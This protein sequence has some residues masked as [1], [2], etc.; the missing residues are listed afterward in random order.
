[1][2]KKKERSTD[3]TAMASKK[4]LDA[5]HAAMVRHDIAPK[6]AIIMFG[7]FARSIVD[8]EVD[9][10]ANKDQFTMMVLQAFTDGLGVKGGFVEMQGELAEQ[11]K[12]QFD[13]QNS[14]TP[15]Q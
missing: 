14:D 6:L 15:L 2:T 5:V 13:Q 3:D 4:F 10:G 8:Y 7:Y 1:M 9:N 11:V 12:A